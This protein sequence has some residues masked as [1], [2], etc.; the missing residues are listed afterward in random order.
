MTQNGSF[1]AAELLYQAA[2]GFRQRGATVSAV[3][4][5]ER[6]LQELAELNTRFAQN[7]MAD[8]AG[9]QLVLRSE[10]RSCS[11][12]YVYSTSWRTGWLVVLLTPSYSTYRYWP[13]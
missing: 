4:S 13:L 10:G 3:H 5:L 11:V 6:G 7:V 8:E 9:Y 12:L 1:P 2:L